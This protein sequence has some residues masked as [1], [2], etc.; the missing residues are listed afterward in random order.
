MARTDNNL[1]LSVLGESAMGVLIFYLPP[2]LWAHSYNIFK[3]R[4]LIATTDARD[5]VPGDIKC[6]MR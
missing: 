1:S 5:E 4:V 6:M 2:C 3:L